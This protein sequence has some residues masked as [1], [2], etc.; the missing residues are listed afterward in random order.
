MERQLDALGRVLDEMPDEPAASRPATMTLSM[1]AMAVDA[2]VPMLGT[3]THLFE[4]VEQHALTKR[5]DIATMV[6]A[7]LTPDMYP[8]PM[9]VQ[10]AC[11]Q[12]WDATARLTGQSSPPLPNIGKR[13]YLRHVGVYMRQR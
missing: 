6:S 7:R 10:L 12:A 9:Q 13:D 5:V 4:K 3:L 8:F 1:D 11:C 2:F